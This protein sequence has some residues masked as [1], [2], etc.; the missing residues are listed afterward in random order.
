M[1]RL[2]SFSDDTYLFIKTNDDTAFRGADLVKLDKDL[3]AID[4]RMLDVVLPEDTYDYDNHKWETENGKALGGL[5]SLI[6]SG[7]YNE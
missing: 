6:D 3:N 5:F 2:I 7:E 1:S 4:K